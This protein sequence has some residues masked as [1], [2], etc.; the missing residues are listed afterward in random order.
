MRPSF[1]LPL[2]SCHD[3]SL[4]GGK[5]F[6]L[7]RLIEAGFPVPSGLCVTTA[8]YTEHLHNSGF[9]DQDEWRRII[10]LSEPDRISALAVCRPRINQIEISQLTT[11]GLTALQALGH[12]PVIL[13]A[14]R[15]SATTEDASDAS[16]A[17]LYRTHLGLTLPEVACAIK[18]LWASLWEMQVVSYLTRQNLGMVPSRMVVVI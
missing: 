11:D 8:A 6:G 5:A 2:S 3:L 12:P 15:S 7:C 17:G 10:G 13:W 1:I 9:H 16:S 4:V 14:V 18:D